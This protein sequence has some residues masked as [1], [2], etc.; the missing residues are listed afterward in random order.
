MKNSLL[1]WYMLAFML[2]SNL[3]VFA[4]PGSGGQGPGGPEGGDEDDVSLNGKIFL[5]GISGIIFAYMYYKRFLSNKQS[6]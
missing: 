6:V 2:V 1:K 5:L 4:Q 3:V